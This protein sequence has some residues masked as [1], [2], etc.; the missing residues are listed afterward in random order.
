S[1]VANRF[2]VRRISLDDLGQLRRDASRTLYCFDVRSPEEYRD[3]HLEGFDGAPG[4][5]LVQ[6]TD[7]YAAVRNARIVLADFD[8]VRA[9][10][11]ASWLLQMGW[12]EVFVLQAPAGAPLAK[13]AGSPR[14]LGP[15][16]TGVGEISAQALRPRLEAGEATVVDLATSIEY[17]DAHIPGAWFAVRSRLREALAKLG[18]AREL[19]FTCPD[20]VLAR[21]AAFDATSLTAIGVRALAGGTAAWRAAGF[22]L[23]AGTARLAGAADDIYYRPYDGRS[24]IEQ[25]MKDYLDWETALVDQLAREPYLKF[26]TAP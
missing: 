26:K 11:T 10:M 14:V 15:E 3:G 13:G 21:L 22:P 17:R 1:R 8:G 25:A 2:G 6:A 12:P 23:E 19:V 24:Q 16:R 18:D 7:R 20:G 4:G 5:Q 9:I